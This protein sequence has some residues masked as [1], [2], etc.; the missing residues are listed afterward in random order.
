MRQKR[1]RH[2][3]RLIRLKNKAIETKTR[4]LKLKIGGGFFVWLRLQ[5]IVSYRFYL[6]ILFIMFVANCIICFK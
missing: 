1:P 2:P 4:S 3:I 5:V 6:W